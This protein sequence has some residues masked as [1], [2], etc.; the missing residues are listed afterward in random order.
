MYCMLLLQKLFR[1]LTKTNIYFQFHL[2]KS[3]R[4]GR[5]V[6]TLTEQVY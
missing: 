2:N 5:V 6:T 3:T 1:T 4:T